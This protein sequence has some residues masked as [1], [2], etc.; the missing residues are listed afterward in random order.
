M[1]RSQCTV[2]E[3][4][5]NSGKRRITQNCVNVF[6]IFSKWNSI[7]SER[8]SIWVP[9]TQNW[10]RFYS[11]VTQ[12]WVELFGRAIDQLRLSLFC[13]TV[14]PCFGSAFPA[15]DWSRVIFF[16]LFFPK[17]FTL[18]DKYTLTQ[19]NANNNTKLCKVGVEQTI[20]IQHKRKAKT[21]TH[22]HTQT[23]KK[24]C[25]IQKIEL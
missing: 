2:K 24:Y 14:C 5:S 7:F 8:N 11:N 19:M 21:N 4:N 10:V 17:H 25:K 6:L 16:L 13:E 23:R 18:T 22:T 15:R 3:V 12:I 1:D 20:N 9:F